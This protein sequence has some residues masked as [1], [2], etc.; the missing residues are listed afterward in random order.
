MAQ[1]HLL[2]AGISYD[3]NKQAVEKNQIIR[4]EG[5][6][7][8]RYVV[9]DIR[10][11]RW[12][13]SYELI[14]LRTHRFGQ[15]DLIR[16]LSQKFGIGYYFNG[17]DPEHMDASEVAALRNEAEQMLQREQEAQQ[18]QQ[19][20]DEE[21]KTIGR[22]RLEAI[23]PA[24]A[25]AVITA[26]LHE[27]ESDSMTDYYG[28]SVQRTVILGFSSHTKDLFPEMRKYA[29]NFEET[30]HLAGYNKEYE[31]REKYTGGD[32]YYLGQNKYSGW[33]VRKET[34]GDRKQ[35][36]ERY[37]LTA[38]NEANI[39][40]SAAPASTDNVSEAVPGDFIIVDYSEKAIAVFGDTKPVKEQLKA[41]GG[42]FN[43]GLT[44]E[45]EKK[46]GWVFSCSKKT[47]LKNLLEKI[48]S[49]L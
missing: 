5:Y 48:A 10:Q 38:G 33:T 34:C 11:T 36:I 21:L 12:G 8:D 49:P 6:D 19:K 30:A 44:H 40:I 22:Q 20:C 27:N 45:G 47:E 35:F 16:P 13:L 9:Y 43:P 46:A 28:Y 39:Y 18:K 24:G 31:N 32:G 25:K 26:E 37:A 2:G 3:T 23:I 4:M 7:Y 42:R 1:V 14:N 29:A 17:N 15:C 41:L